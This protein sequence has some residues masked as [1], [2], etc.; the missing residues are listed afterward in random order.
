M[1][2]RTDFC[3]TSNYFSCHCSQLVSSLLSLC[4][5]FRF[6]CSLS[7]ED[8]YYLC[9]FRTFLIRYYEMKWKK[10]LILEVLGVFGG[11]SLKLF[12]L[13]LVMDGFVSVS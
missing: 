1:K 11:G 9:V 6:V 13:V 3:S 8:M 12:G 7:V 10:P 4:L 5:N 2:I